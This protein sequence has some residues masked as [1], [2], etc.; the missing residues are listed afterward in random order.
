MII[1][2]EE[3]HYDII[4]AMA[5]YARK[6]LN[7]AHR[8]L[9]AIEDKIKN[10]EQFPQ[11]YPIKVRDQFRRAVL[12]KFPYSIYYKL[13]LN[14]DIVIYAVLSNKIDSKIIEKNI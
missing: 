14:G 8:F 2:R 7:L 1:A 9:D 12:S 4:A 5:H 6:N 13:E 10:I 11:S 3:A